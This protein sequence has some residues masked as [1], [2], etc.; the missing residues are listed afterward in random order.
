MKTLLPLLAAAALAAPAAHGRTPAGLVD[1]DQAR[2]LAGNITPTD[3]AGF[4]VV[5]SQPG[6]YRL[7]SDL[8]VADPST[9]G[10]VI[11]SPHVTL[12]LNGFT[13]RGPV[14]CTGE[15]TVLTCS[16][17]GM[18]TT[19]GFG[20]HV[21]LPNTFGSTVL[22]RDG[23]VAGFAG[24]GVYGGAGMRNVDVH[25]MRISGNGQAGVFSAG[26]VTDS[27]ISRNRGQ[28]LTFVQRAMGNTITYNRDWGMA[29]VTGR[30][31][32]LSGNYGGSSG[33]Q[34]YAYTLLD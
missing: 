8:Q 4:P 28:G 10:V 5:I 15:A 29:L 1:I 21:H 22:V 7:T 27:S 12:D 2:A 23:T 25:R 9:S 18:G 13:I 33:S 30:F 31:N 32:Y 3:P 26:S 14:T 11:T 24:H 6:S 20:I 16:S 19:R 17:D 34:T